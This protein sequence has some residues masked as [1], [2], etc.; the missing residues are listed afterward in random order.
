[1]DIIF[2]ARAFVSSRY[3]GMNEMLPPYLS[4]IIVDLGGILTEP[5][6]YSPK[7]FSTASIASLIVRIPAISSSDRYNMADSL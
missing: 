6:A 3:E 4:S 2:V 5:F 7:A 1:M